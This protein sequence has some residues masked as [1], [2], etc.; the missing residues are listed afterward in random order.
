MSLYRPATIFKLTPT[1]QLVATI[2]GTPWTPSPAPPPPLSTNSSS[3]SLRKP[4]ASGLRS[5]SPISPGTAGG[6]SNPYNQSAK[7]PNENYFASLGSANEGRR[8]DL[9]PSQGG[10]YGGFG[11]EGS[12]MGGSEA[13]SSRALPSFD[14]LRDDPVSALGR[15]WGFLGAALGQA[16]RSINE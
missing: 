2:A 1:I 7:T 14:D 16:S 10:R 3:S 11:S 9:P 12:S 4:R 6:I 15:G 5:A 13:T 8:A